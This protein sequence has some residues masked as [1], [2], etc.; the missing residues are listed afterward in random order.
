MLR[1]CHLHPYGYR[2]VGGF[3][4]EA[5]SAV[6]AKGFAQGDLDV[7]VQA[8]VIRG[9]ADFPLAVWPVGG[10]GMIGLTFVLQVATSN[11]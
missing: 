9:P 8:P 3:L 7:S 6:L 2:I 5:S 1:V 4:P 11:F 10:L